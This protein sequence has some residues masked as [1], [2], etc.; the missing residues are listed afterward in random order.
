MVLSIFLKAL[1]LKISLR[2]IYKCFT[3][4]S[5]S[6]NCNDNLK[7]GEDFFNQ[8]AK[9]P[10]T[11]FEYFYNTAYQSLLWANEENEMLLILP[12]HAFLHLT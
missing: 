10:D 9:S 12:A 7:R 8:Q 5:S 11:I 1:I 2:N 3:T 6:F 4:W